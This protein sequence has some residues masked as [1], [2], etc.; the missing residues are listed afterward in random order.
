MNPRADTMAVRSLDE[1]FQ[2]EVPAVVFRGTKTGNLGARRPSYTYGTIVDGQKQVGGINEGVVLY[3]P[4]RED[5]KAMLK[6]LEAY[7]IPSLGAEQDFLT[8]F[9]KERNSRGITSLPRPYNVQ[10]HMA[11]MV[12]HEQPT[13]SWYRILLKD[14]QLEVRNWHFSADPIPWIMFGARCSK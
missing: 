14:W 5:Y 11:M 3:R 7:R 10:I 9:W 2:Y 1:V 12:G 13:D 4:N 6:A 8:D